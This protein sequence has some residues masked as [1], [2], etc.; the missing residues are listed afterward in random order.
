[1]EFKITY[2]GA[3]WN[4]TDLEGV[5]DPEENSLRGTR[6]EWPCPFVLKRHPD[7]VRFL[8]SPYGINAR[9]RWN[10][11][12]KSVL[13]RV[14]QQAW[15]SKRIFQRIKDGK[16]FMELTLMA[17]HGKPIIDGKLEEFTALLPGLYE[18]DTRFYASLNKIKLSHIYI[19][20]RIRCDKCEFITGGSRIICLDCRGDTTV[21]LCSGPECLSSTITFE[22]VD[23]RPHLPTHGMIKTHRFIYDTEFGKIEEDAKAR[24]AFIRGMIP[25]R[26]EVENRFFNCDTC[27]TSLSAPCWN[28]LD[29]TGEGGGWLIN[30]EN[31]ERQ[32]LTFTKTHTKSHIILRIPEKEKT[33][34]TEERLQFLEDKLVKIEEILAKLVEKSTEGPRSDPV[35]GEE[36]RVAATKSTQSGEGPEVKEET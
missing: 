35:T 29:C 34:P 32:D 23:R 25:Q 12:L 2:K 24:L 36:P 28:C 33:R 16:R 31:C 5:F 19:F 11:A 9:E 14:R 10:F 27:D 4:D 17:P 21:D 15:S 6:K 26:D 1:V 3:S 30:C 8:P 13:D 20:D 18:A 22:A 7:Y